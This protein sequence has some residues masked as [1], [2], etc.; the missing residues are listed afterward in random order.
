MLNLDEVK[1]EI[2]SSLLPLEP[3]KIIVFGSYADGTA[4]EESDLDLFLVKDQIDDMLE[5][6]LQA[7]KK[8]RNFILTHSTNGIDVLSASDEYL[9][10][11]NDYFYKEVLEKGKVLY[12]RNISR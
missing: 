9:K 4:T 8:L 10:T 6:E 1:D 7:R 5:Y 3:D 11:R 12:E 2:V